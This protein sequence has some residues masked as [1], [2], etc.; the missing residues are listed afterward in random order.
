MKEEPTWTCLICGKT[1]PNRL[2]S[3]HQIFLEDH[4]NWGVERNFRHCIDNPDCI[5]A[6]IGIREKEKENEEH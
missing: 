6:V 5:K 1:R 3:V 4:G 2:M